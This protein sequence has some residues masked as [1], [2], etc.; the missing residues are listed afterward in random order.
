VRS[1]SSTLVQ[2]RD[3]E[4]RM[5]QLFCPSLIVKAATVFRSMEG[6]PPASCQASRLAGRNRVD[7]ARNNINIVISIARSSSIAVSAVPVST[8]NNKISESVTARTDVA[9]IAFARC[10][11]SLTWY[12]RRVKSTPPHG[13][14]S[15]LLLLLLFSVPPRGDG[16]S[17][18]RAQLL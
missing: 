13:I 5:W 9:A 8:R 10:A 17:C 1:N 12:R 4:G 18:R 6:C 14:S 7:T 15:L 16:A 11:A 2:K 3:G